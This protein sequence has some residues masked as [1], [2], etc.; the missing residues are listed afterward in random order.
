MVYFKTK[1]SDLG[2]FLEFL[3]WKML[4]YFWPFGILYDNLVHALAILYM[5]WLFG[6]CFG[7]LVYVLATRNM[8]G[9]LGIFCGHLIYFSFFGMLYPE[10]SFNPDFDLLFLVT[11]AQTGL[12]VFISFY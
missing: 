10:N 6:V 9:P 5:F 2:I 11:V 8:S 1:N 7:H 4:V 12:D 3:E